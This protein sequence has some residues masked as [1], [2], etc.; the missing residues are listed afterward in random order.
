MRLID[1]NPKWQSISK[2]RFGQGISFNCP[3]LNSDKDLH[4]SCRIDLWFENPLDGGSKIIS[5]KCPYLNIYWTI[6]GNSFDNL[7]ISPSVGYRCRHGHTHIFV[8]NG[9]IINC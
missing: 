6:Q 7:T 9:E 8:T 4:G 1:L 3:I 5:E 2:E